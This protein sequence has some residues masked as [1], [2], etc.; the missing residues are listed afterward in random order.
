M[1]ISGLPRGDTVM[2]S[3]HALL[4]VFALFPACGGAATADAY[5]QRPILVQRLKL[6]GGEYGPVDGGFEV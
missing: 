5:P 1:R 2:R 4:L 3:L 6:I